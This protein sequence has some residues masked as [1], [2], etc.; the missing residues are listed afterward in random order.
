MTERAV[1]V[2]NLH[3]EPPEVEHMVRMNR[4]PFSLACFICFVSSALA[5][6]R[7]LVADPKESTVDS[8]LNKGYT[9]IGRYLDCPVLVPDGVLPSPLAIADFS[10]AADMKLV[11][12]SPVR[13]P[14]VFPESFR[15][16]VI[17]ERN[18]VLLLKV[19]DTVDTGIF[20]AAGYEVKVIPIRPIRKPRSTLQPKVSRAAQSLIQS[21]VDQV[22]LTNYQALLN[23]LV[24]FGDRYSCAPGHG[25]NAATYIYNKFSSYG[26]TNIRYQ[27][28]DSCSDNVIAKKTGSINP[29]RVWVIGAHYDSYAQTNA[30]GADDNGSGTGA[31]LE[32][33]RILNQYNLEDTIEFALFASEELGLFGSE[34]YAAA[35]DSANTNIVGMINLDM[36]GYEKPGYP[37]DLDVVA[38]SAS[39]WLETIAFQAIDD[40]IPGTLKKDN[41]LPSGAGSDHEPFNEH[42]YSAIMFFEDEPNYSPYIHSANDTIPLSLN[43]WPLAMNFTK[44]ALATLA[45]CAI[46]LDIYLTAHTID[47]SSGIMTGMWIRVSRSI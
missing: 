5:D 36:I 21:M 37:A 19:N 11:V 17:I 3:V 42:G 7:I 40:Y 1:C 13:S 23:D 8:L 35:A 27:S 4:L 31:V 32:I 30:P 16:S 25:A 18:G 28:F 45:T 38:D 44:A 46:P 39:M 12:I 20:A 47:D 6:T 15:T 2:C 22:S 14:L 9:V 29:D 24:A 43:S 10:M 41:E 26:F 33:A 34:A